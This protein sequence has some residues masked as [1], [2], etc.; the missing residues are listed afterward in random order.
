M[1]Q[2][3]HGPEFLEPN[4]SRRW[5]PTPP[6]DA[7]RP[8]PPPPPTPRRRCRCAPAQVLTVLIDPHDHRAAAMQIDADVLLP[9]HR[10]LPPS[11]RL[12]FGN[13]ECFSTRTHSTAGDPDLPLRP[14]RSSHPD[15][16]TT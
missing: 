5:P 9:F 10:G 15:L 13:P 2:V 7:H 12:W 16:T 3:R 14:R 4:T 8:W 11:R 1:R 6:P